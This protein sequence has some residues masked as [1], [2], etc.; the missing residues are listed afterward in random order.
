MRIPAVI[1]IFVGLP[2]GGY[3]LYTVATGNFHEV[4]AGQVFRSGQLSKAELT[5]KIQRYGIKS[6]LN[7]RGKNAGRNWYDDEIEVCKKDGVVHYDVP[8]SAGKD[9]SV[10]RM[11]ALVTIL[12]KAPKPLLIHCESGA[13][14][15]AFGAAL[16]HLAVE[17]KSA[18]EADNELTIWYGHLPSIRREV[19]A[20][21]RS[22]LRYIDGAG[23]RKTQTSPTRNL[24]PLWQEVGQFST[25]TIVSGSNLDDR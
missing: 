12:K 16:Y 5:A 4:V 10:K 25:S 6:V 1:L 19:Q 8:L 14:R 11:D 3:T 24:L 13:D 2:L 22:F 20:M 21:D 18:A 7:L 23:S 9:V 15:A 17:G